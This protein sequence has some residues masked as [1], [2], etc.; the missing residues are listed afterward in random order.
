MAG[1]AIKPVLYYVG[2]S[3]TRRGQTIPVPVAEQWV[4]YLYNRKDI[5]S[6]KSE[7]RG[8]LARTDKKGVMYSCLSD[9]K[10]DG[11][12]F[13]ASRVVSPWIMKRHYQHRY[14][15]VLLPVNKEVCLFIWPFKYVTT[16][17]TT[18]KYLSALDLAKRGQVK[19]ST[20]DIYLPCPE[21]IYIERIKKYTKTLE[22]KNTAYEKR[23]AKS[24]TCG[25]LLDQAY[26][27]VVGRGRDVQL[28][29]ALKAGKKGLY[30]LRSMIY[31][32]PNVEA[33]AINVA[34]VN[35]MKNKLAAYV[36]G[37]TRRYK[38][39]IFMD[40]QILYAIFLSGVH[41]YQ[42]SHTDWTKEGGKTAKEP[43]K[44]VIEAYDSSYDALIKT[45]TV[46]AAKLYRA[47]FGKVVKKAS[48]GK[49]QAKQAIKELDKKAAWVK[50]SLSVM[51]IVADARTYKMAS[52]LRK[53][54]TDFKGACRFLEARGIITD[55]DKL[56]LELDRSLA[57]G[58]P[59]NVDGY[60]EKT[61][62]PIPSNI[63]ASIKS[64]VSAISMLNA[65]QKQ[66]KNNRDT[67]EKVTSVYGFATD[68]MDIPVIQSRIPKGAIISKGAGTVGAVADW[69]ISIYDMYNAADTG[70]G[71]KFGYAVVS[72]AGKGFV[73][74]GTV[75]LLTPFA[76]LGALLIGFGA[77]VSLIG[78]ICKGIID[79]KS[80]EEKKFIMMIETKLSEH[81]PSRSKW[82]SE[83]YKLVLKKS[84][85]KNHA[86]VK[87]IKRQNPG[88]GK[89]IDDVIGEKTWGEYISKFFSPGFFSSPHWGIQDEML[90]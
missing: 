43:P 32:S 38:R 11:K 36:K 14:L 67:V 42:Y 56:E 50:N 57:R 16:R 75:L 60:F 70:N 79:F 76:P 44:A 10:F 81:D 72:Y 34:V 66:S 26:N 31:G 29:L 86:V 35:E 6:G 77:A 13:Y 64:G 69:G 17:E 19:S 46:T 71:K 85:V 8:G 37:E 12:K 48:G 40:V 62:T 59:V 1:K 68:V 54:N 80:I 2:E 30:K 45:G 87:E 28:S 61:P 41:Q 39:R 47:H 27:L 15:P 84:K 58:T 82:I 49:S 51:K 24:V 23:I 22:K 53:L 4:V 20:R 33:T 52:D 25:G 74:G 88:R 7:L 65:L 3:I 73:A 63:K 21:G 5:F 89:L 83:H 18:I 90:D 9:L 55:F 78:S